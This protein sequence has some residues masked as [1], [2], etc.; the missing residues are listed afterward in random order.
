MHEMIFQTLTSIDKGRLVENLIFLGV[1]MLK[2]GPHLT[3]IEQ[4]MDQ[5]AKAV[6]TGFKDGEKRFERLERRVE[7]I[8]DGK[9][10]RHSEADL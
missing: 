2:F 8:E 1:L 9:P 10:A 7:R 3:K 6:E 4:R 5:L